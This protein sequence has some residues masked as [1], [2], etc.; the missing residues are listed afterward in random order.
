MPLGKTKWSTGSWVLVSAVGFAGLANGC[1]TFRSPNSLTTVRA[2]S[3]EETVVLVRHGE[4]APG[5]LGQLSCKGLNRALALPQ[6][7]LNRFGVAN[8]IYAPDPSVQITE[9]TPVT[10][11][12]YVRPLATIE[13][14][15]IRIGAPV[16]TQIAYSDPSSLQTAVTNPT[17]ARA[18]IFIAWEHVNAYNF[19][20]NILTSYGQDPS[21]VPKWKESDFDMIYVFHIEPPVADGS[22]HGQLTFDVE[23]EDLNDQIGRGCPTPQ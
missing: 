2:N 9:G 5:G 18:T 13:P 21:V 15:A 14:T 16:N 10:S 3:N 17:Y 8:A 11:Y 22:G 20:R 23:Q 4:I 1:S 7:L 19:A 12:S 6:V